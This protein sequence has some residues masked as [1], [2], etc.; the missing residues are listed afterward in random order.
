MPSGPRYC[1]SSP[2]LWRPTWYLFDIQIL[3]LFA[4]IFHWKI[5]PMRSCLF[6]HFIITLRALLLGTLSW[7][8]SSPLLASHSVNN[9]ILLILLS[10]WYHYSSHS[11]CLNTPN[12]P[13]WGHFIITL[14]WTLL[15]CSQF[16][17]TVYTHRIELHTELVE[18]LKGGH[19][20]S[21]VV[22]KRAWA[23]LP[24]MLV[25]SVSIVTIWAA[26]SVM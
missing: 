22:I 6:N 16:S 12:R 9:L 14:I 8:N 13:N 21:L 7:H 24:L 20:A 23:V 4:N 25:S 15:N 10:V 1:M 5:R 3:F 2:Y 18:Q 26:V 19:H 17:I 11:I